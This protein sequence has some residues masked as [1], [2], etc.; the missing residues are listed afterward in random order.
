MHVCVCVF[1]VQA[2][3]PVSCLE[4]L[5]ALKTARLDHGWISYASLEA[6]VCLGHRDRRS[7]PQAMHCVSSADDLLG[8]APLCVTGLAGCLFVPA[9]TSWAPKRVNGPK[10]CAVRARIRCKVSFVTGMEMRDVAAIL[11]VLVSGGIALSTRGAYV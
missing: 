7:T 6:S 10:S 1:A 8:T 2:L 5:S 11:A 9:P 4:A 3:Q